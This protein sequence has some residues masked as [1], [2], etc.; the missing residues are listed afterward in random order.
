MKCAMKFLSVFLILLLFPGILFALDN[1]SD[2]ATEVDPLAIDNNSISVPLQSV[3]LLA[4]KNN[5]DINFASLQPDIAETDITREKSAYDTLFTSQYSKYHENKQVGNALSGSSSSPEIYQEK[6]NFDAGLKKKFTLGTQTELKLKQEEYKSNTSFLGLKPQYYGDLT[7]SITQP[8]LKDFGIEIGESLIKIA[9]L[10]FEVSENEFKKQVMDVLFQVE[11]YYWDLYFRINDLSSKENSLKLADDLL[12][13]FKIR[14][15]AGALAPIEIYQAEAE[16]ALRTEDVI[17]A[18]SNV[19]KAEDNLKAAL[20]LYEDEKYWDTVVIPSDTPYIK[21]EVPDLSK[22]LNTALE[23][24]PDFKQAKLNI[25]AANIQLKYSKNQTLPRIDLIGSIGT[26]GLAGKPQDTSGAF[27]RKKI[28]SFGSKPSLSPWDG[29]WS[30]VY[31]SMDDGDY[32]TYTIGFKVEFPLENRLAKSQLAKAKVKKL[33][34]ITSLKTQENVIINEVRDALRYVNTTSQVIDTAIASLRLAR[35]KLKAEEKKY[36]VGMSTTHDLLEFQDDLAKAESTLA[37]A[38]S[39]HSKSLSN[40]SRV[41]G[42]L[43]EDKG[44]TL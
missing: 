43:L 16:V 42:I 31:D 37:F 4:I 15:E 26:N 30:D 18:R 24:R 40:L 10:N 1:E 21:K 7:M 12:R 25:Q 22:C 41:M 5:L 35:E 38:R 19:K 11:S 23:N 17:V 33:Q 32:Y 20:N 9:S 29:H 13:E 39:E 2:N 28:F 34:S 3:L 44:L 6:Y 27:G 36:K 14:I 8:L